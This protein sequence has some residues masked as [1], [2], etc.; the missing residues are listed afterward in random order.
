M[1]GKTRKKACFSLHFLGGIKTFQRVTEEKNKKIPC[2]P[3][4]RLRLCADLPGKPVLRPSSL[5]AQPGF[6]PL[7]PIS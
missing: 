7:N 1:Q 6:R 5:A 3:N 4:S 2:R